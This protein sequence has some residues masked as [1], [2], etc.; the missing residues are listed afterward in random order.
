[1]ERTRWGCI[2]GNLG[3]SWIIVAGGIY[4]KGRKENFKR[5]LQGALVLLGMIFAGKILRRGRKREGGY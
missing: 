5:T 1:M 2:L 4:R 3:R